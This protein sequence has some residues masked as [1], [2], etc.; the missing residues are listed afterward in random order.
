MEPKNWRKNK[1]QH[2]KSWEFYRAEGGIH[3]FKS[4]EVDG[5]TYKFN[6]WG[7]LRIRDKS[8]ARAIRDKYGK[9]LASAEVSD[10]PNPRKDEAGH[11]FFF[12]VP[13]MPWKRKRNGRAREAHEQAHEEKA[14][15]GDG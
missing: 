4:V 6:R 11:R 9:A 13:E 1:K 10:V 5:K 7:A 3:S 2:S 8:V 15:G 12:S 14:R